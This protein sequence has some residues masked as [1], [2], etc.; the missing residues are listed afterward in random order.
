MNSIALRVLVAVL[1][2]IAYER[3]AHAGDLTVTRVF[4]PEV[5]TGPYKH[6]ACLTE[7]KNGDLYLVYYG[8]SG[9]Y[10]VETAV[11]GSRL[12]KGESHWTPPRPI[13]QRSAPLGWQRRDLGGSR[14][15]RLA[16]LRRPVRGNMVDVA[17]SVQDLA[18]QRRDLV[19]RLGPVTRRGRHGP[20]PAHRA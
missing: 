4:G 14:R 10:A 11:F 8:G 15:R 1:P 2:V 18:R 7:L 12:K 9:E 6:P 16:V 20:R 3:C 5:P 19:G 13:A 17:D